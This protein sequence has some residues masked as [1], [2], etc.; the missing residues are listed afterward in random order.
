MERAIELDSPLLVCWMEH[1]W[2]LLLV[3][4]EELWDP[5]LGLSSDLLELELLVE[6]WGHWLAE[7]EVGKP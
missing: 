4:L 5:Q 6:M 2:D 1:G 3:R 7:G